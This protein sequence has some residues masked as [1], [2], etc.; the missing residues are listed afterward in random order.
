MQLQTELL[1]WI[2]GF[3]ESAIKITAE[4]LTTL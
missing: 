4:N 2:I 3:K 1:F